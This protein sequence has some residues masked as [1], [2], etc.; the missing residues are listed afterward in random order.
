MKFQYKNY[1][2]NGYIHQ[3]I[4]NCIFL[5]SRGLFESDWMV[6]HPNKIA[7][8][9]VGLGLKMSSHVD[10]I[11]LLITSHVLHRV[12]HIQSFG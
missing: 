5:V 1:D 11:L 8:K 6:F 7:L 3:L 4:D 9:S 2:L 12:F 10:F